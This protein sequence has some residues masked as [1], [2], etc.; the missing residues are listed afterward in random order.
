MD[1]SHGPRVRHRP[2]GSLRFFT[3]AMGRDSVGNAWKVNRTLEVGGSTPLGS[4]YCKRTFPEG[5][6]ARRDCREACAE[7]STCTARGAR[8]RTLAYVVRECTQD[9]QGRFSLKQKL[10]VRRGNCDL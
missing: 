1:T 4:T 6:Q 9:T 10:P 3:H 8:I 5:G 7:R 2:P